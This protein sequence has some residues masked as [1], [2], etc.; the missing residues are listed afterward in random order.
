[1]M[2]TVVP[3]GRNE[4]LLVGAGPAVCLADELEDVA[5]ACAEDVG[6]DV[7]ADPELDDD[8]A[9]LWVAA[10]EAAPVVEVELDDPPHA[11]SSSSSEPSPA[12]TIHPP[13]R[14]T[15]SPLQDHP[16]PRGSYAVCRGLTYPT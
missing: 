9:V 15:S 6:D 16:A 1:M 5:W 14:I 12:A 11:V 8:E 2:R 7:V 13:L 4:T 3:T 10:P